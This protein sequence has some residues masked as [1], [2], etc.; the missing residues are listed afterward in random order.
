MDTRKMSSLRIS[1]IARIKSL[2]IGCE[3]SKGTGTVCKMERPRILG[4]GSS[5]VGLSIYLVT[6]CQT[7]NA[8]KK[9]SSLSVSANP[10]LREGL[11]EKWATAKS[12]E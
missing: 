2:G 8:R 4:F 1:P 3:W 9:V 10:V 5:S 12:V 7:M 6:L 11:V